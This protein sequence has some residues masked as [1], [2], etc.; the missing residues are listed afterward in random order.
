MTVGM[1][2]IVTAIASG[3]G[4]RFSPEIRDIAQLASQNNAGFRDKCFLEASGAQFNSNCIEQGDKPLLLLWG[5][6][7]AAALYPRT[8][9]GS[10]HRPVS[11]GSLC[12]ACVCA[13][14]GDRIQCL[15]RQDQ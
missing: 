9:K 14:S 5:D 15:V 13:D 10:G 1:I 11:P 4:F 7:T 3:F 8:K 6:S 12:G 2:G